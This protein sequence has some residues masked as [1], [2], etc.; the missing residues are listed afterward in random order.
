MFEIVTINPMK[1]CCPEGTFANSY[2][3]D[4]CLLIEADNVISY[5]DK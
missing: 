1:R 4:K 3:N 5:S 2:E